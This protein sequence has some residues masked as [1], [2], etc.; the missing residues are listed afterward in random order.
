[1]A[2]INFMISNQNRFMMLTLRRFPDDFLPFMGKEKTAIDF[3]I[4]E[5]QGPHIPCT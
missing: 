4:Y 2:P 5:V 3:K 1:M